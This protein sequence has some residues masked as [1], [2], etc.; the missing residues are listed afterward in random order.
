MK[1]EISA[2]CL[3]LTENGEKIHIRF[4]RGKASGKHTWCGCKV[5]S[6]LKL[7]GLIGMTEKAEELCKTCLRGYKQEQNKEEKH[8]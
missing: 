3:C 8:V 7:D 5:T 4:I 1:A 6:P 2:Q